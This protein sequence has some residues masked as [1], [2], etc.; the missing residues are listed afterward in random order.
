MVLQK[1]VDHLKS[2]PRD[3]RRA[4]A[5]GVALLIVAILFVGWAIMFFKRIQS[6]SIRTESIGTSVNG[7]FNFSAIKE[8]Q[9]QL[10][11]GYRNP[12]NP[13]S[14]SAEVELSAQNGY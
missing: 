8:S 9:Q 1:S 3:E 13:A 4:V 12:S 5:L 10:L 14:Q 7:S 2:R 6:S 11:N